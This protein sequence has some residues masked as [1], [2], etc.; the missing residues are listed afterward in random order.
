MARSPWCRQAAAVCLWAEG[1]AAWERGGTYRAHVGLLHCHSSPL[2]SLPQQQYDGKYYALK[3]LSKSHVVSTGLQARGLA[4]G[5]WLVGECR[6][7]PASSVAAFSCMSHPTLSLDTLA[8]E[9]IKR[10][11]SIMA[12]F[13]SP[14]LVNLVAAFQVRRSVLRWAVRAHTVLWFAVRQSID[15]PTL[16]VPLL[17][18]CP[19]GHVLAVHGDGAGPGRRVLHLPAGVYLRGGLRAGGLASLVLVVPGEFLSER[20]LPAHLLPQCQ[21]TRTM[22][23]GPRGAAERGGGALLHRLRGAGPGVHAR[24]RRG[25]AVRWPGC[26]LAWLLIE[27]SQYS[28][29][30]PVRPSALL[31]PPSSR[32]L[33]APPLG[34]PRRSDLKPEN[35]LIDT[36]GYLKI[37]DF[38]FA[39][40]VSPVRRR[41]LASLSFGRPPPAQHNSLPAADV[42]RPEPR[43]CL[44]PL[45][46]PSPCLSTHSPTDRQDVHAVR[47][48][49]VPGPRAGHA[50]RAQ[51]GRRLVRFP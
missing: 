44:M 2:S 29:G 14:F 1:T 27:L 42:P 51:Q 50:E 46:L 3:A 9:H 47:H 20:R 40:K 5:R 11:K 25:L 10:E 41:F 7:R 15:R 6:L 48:A 16:V 28:V 34:S 43:S 31:P 21:H 12:E 32:A 49:R 45:P 26:L 4:D 17:S 37:T 19:A 24:P 22:H 39:K 35:L 8:Q 36:Q 30:H 18:F 13:G 33:P 38:G 23:I